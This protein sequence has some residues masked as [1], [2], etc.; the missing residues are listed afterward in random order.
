MGSGIQAIGKTNELLSVMNVCWNASHNGAMTH[1]YMLQINESTIYRIFVACVV[2]MEAIF[3]CFNLKPD[4]CNL[5]TT[6]LLHKHS[7]WEGFCWN[8]SDWNGVTVQ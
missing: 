2:L 5:A 7:Y 1:S 4:D 8:L 3:P 6:I